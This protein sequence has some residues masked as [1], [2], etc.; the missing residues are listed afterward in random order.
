MKGDAYLFVS[1]DEEQD[2]A[3][4]E[5]AIGK[6]I[7]RVTVAGFDYKSR[8]AEKL[9][10]PLG[11]RLPGMRAATTAAPRRR[12][13]PPAIPAAIARRAAPTAARSGRA[14]ATAEDARRARG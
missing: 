8:P 2:A 12:A 1:P 7:P 3:R 4:I 13:R 10:I 6:R 14:R 9:E 11:Q 5:R